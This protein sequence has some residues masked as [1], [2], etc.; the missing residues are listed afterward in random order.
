MLKGL[1]LYLSMS[2]LN[3]DTHVNI[4]RISI[5][6]TIASI[7]L[8]LPMNLS[9]VLMIWFIL[10]HDFDLKKTSSAI[11]IAFGI[12]Q[13]DFMYGNL[14]INKSLVKEILDCFQSIV[15]RSN[16]KVYFFISS[17]KKQK[18]I[19]TK[20]HKNFFHRK[21]T[22]SHWFLFMFYRILNRLLNLKFLLG[23]R[24]FEDIYQNVELKNEKLVN[25]GKILTKI[26]YITLFGVPFLLPICYAFVHFPAPPWPLPFPVTYV[27]H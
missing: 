17:W 18:K 13:I 23:S 11:F 27:W 22:Q 16:F 15:D 12:I 7:L 10:D 24:T 5:S 9:L 25:F 14:V 6:S 3:G 19:Q 8:V 4:G 20:F 1:R 26:A 21:L 2:Y